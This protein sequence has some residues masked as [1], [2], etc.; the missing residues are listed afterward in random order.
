MGKST[1]SDASTED[2]IPFGLE[3]TEQGDQFMAVKPW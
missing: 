3:K 1:V 2:D